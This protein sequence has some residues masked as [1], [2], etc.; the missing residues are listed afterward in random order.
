MSYAL[1]SPGLLATRAV[2]KADEITLIETASDLLVRAQDS[3]V[4]ARAEADQ[5]RAQARD[6]GRQ[7]GVEEVRREVA[8]RLAA[9]AEDL[10]REQRRR[11]EELGTA[12]LAAVEAIIGAAGLEAIGPALIQQALSGFVGD[13]AVVVRVAPGMAKPLKKILREDSRVTVEVDAAL[14]PLDCELRTGRGTIRAGL[15][16]QL[17]ALAERW[18]VAR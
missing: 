6:E 3:V 1:L 15:S 12:A 16:V 9:L 13:E 5:L 17:A 2:I 4:R 11:D 18:E 10:A 14:E 8:D 7:Q